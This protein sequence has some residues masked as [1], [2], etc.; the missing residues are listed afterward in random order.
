MEFPGIKGSSF[1]VI[2]NKELSSGLDYPIKW[3]G[4]LL[5]LHT[6]HTPLKLNKKDYTKIKTHKVFKYRFKLTNV[7][8]Q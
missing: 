8:P 1:G 7:K 6:R 5:P 3:T 4:V 2:L